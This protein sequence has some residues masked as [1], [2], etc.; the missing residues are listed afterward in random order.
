MTVLVVDPSSSSLDEATVS[1]ARELQRLLASGE[2]P[3]RLVVPSGEPM[4]LPDSLD[5]VVREAI[6]SAA[7]GEPVAVYPVQ[8]QLTTREAAHVLGMSRPTLIG[9]LE[10]GEIPFQM[11]GTHRRVRLTDL[12]RYRETRA[13][14][15]EEHLDAILAEAQED[16]GY[17]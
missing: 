15:A 9:L 2:G 7:S 17:F 5:W 11:T 13:R 4:P 12:L 6:A 8:R 14:E 3:V 16:E 1:A 10:R